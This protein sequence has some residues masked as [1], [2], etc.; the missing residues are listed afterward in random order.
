MEIEDCIFGIRYMRGGRL[1]LGLATLISMCIFSPISSTCIWGK[2][3]NIFNIANPRHITPV[4][5][6]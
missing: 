6:V 1:V 5:L 2:Y 3:S 4:Y